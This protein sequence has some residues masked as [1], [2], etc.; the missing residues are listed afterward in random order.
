MKNYRFLKPLRIEPPRRFLKNDRSWKPP[1]IEQPR[2]FL[3][4]IVFSNRR[5]SNCRGGF[6]KIER[7]LKSPRIEPLRRFVKNERF[8]KPLRVEPPRWFSKYERVLKLSEFFFSRSYLYNR[9][10][11]LF[12]LACLA[13]GYGWWEVE[14]SRRPLLHPLLSFSFCCALFRLMTVS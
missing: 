3:K 4:M 9:A 13:S 8:F 5:E 12:V 10:V 6:Q 11:T 14:A 1:R 7:F 2:R